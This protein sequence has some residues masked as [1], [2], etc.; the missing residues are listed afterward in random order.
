MEASIFAFELAQEEEELTQNMRAA[1]R[2]EGEVDDS[3]E[4][5]L[6][7]GTAVPSYDSFHAR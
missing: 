7:M 6:T 5:E 2:C 3:A 1:A 4:M